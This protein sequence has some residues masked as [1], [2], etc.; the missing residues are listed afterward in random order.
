M[1]GRTR[2]NNHATRLGAILILP[3]ALSACDWRKELEYGSHIATINPESSSSAFA[4]HQTELSHLVRFAPGAPIVAPT[5]ILA[6]NQFIDAVGVQ[7]NDDVSA[8]VSGPLAQQRA[9]AVVQ[10]FSLRGHRITPRIDPYGSDG[11]VTVNIRRVVYTASACLG[12]GSPMA[13]GATAM[14]FGCANALNLQSMVAEPDELINALGS[15]SVET[16]PAVS[17]VTRYR[18]GDITP[19]QIEGTTESSGN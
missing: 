1:P 12:D 3:L 14:P 8:V 5:E 19:L 7:A 10:A 9:D 11:D 13:D 18:N 15:N 17:A 2:V 16:D 4:W 6:L